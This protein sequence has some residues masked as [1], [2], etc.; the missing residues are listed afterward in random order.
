ME[1]R[2]DFL[3]TDRQLDSKFPV[4]D[5]GYSGTCGGGVT[6][7]T[8]V[9]GNA[10][11]PANSYFVGMLVELGWNGYP[12]ST[13]KQ[14]IRRITA[15]DSATDK[16]TVEANWSPLPSGADPLANWTWRIL[17]INSANYYTNA[18]VEETLK[19]ADGNPYY[20]GI[21]YFDYD[22][23]NDSTG[24]GTFG[25]PYKTI[26]GK[27][28][29]DKLCYIKSD[30]MELD[31]GTLFT[32]NGDGI[33]RPFYIAG[34]NKRVRMRRAIYC[35]GDCIDGAIFNLDFVIIT[36]WV[37]T[38]PFH[39]FYLGS[40]S[41]SFHFQRY[42]ITAFAGSMFACFWNAQGVASNFTPNLSLANMTL[43][44]CHFESLPSVG[45][46]ANLLTIMETSLV[47]N[48]TMTANLALIRAA[49]SGDLIVSGV[50]ALT[51]TVQ[52]GGTVSGTLAL[53]N[54]IPS[55][56]R[57]SVALDADFHNIAYWRMSC[58][59][60]I[61]A[62]AYDWPLAL[63]TDRFSI[64]P[65]FSAVSRLE[66]I[67]GT[68]SVRAF[69]KRNQRGLEATLTMTEDDFNDDILE[70]ALKPTYYL[71]SDELRDETLTITSQTGVNGGKGNLIKVNSEIP[72]ASR[73]EMIG[74]VDMGGGVT[75]WVYFKDVVSLAGVYYYKVMT[76]NAA[77]QYLFS[78][79][80]YKG[81]SIRIHYRLYTLTEAPAVDRITY[82]L[83]NVG[84]K[85][86]AKYL[87][88]PGEQSLL[89]G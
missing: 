26:S 68:D 48:I 24:T 46:P 62:S 84:L 17:T 86:A 19:D 76:I 23:G 21:L 18:E 74:S 16:I 75:V 67:D 72:K 64:K 31:T 73:L 12:T 30:T 20:S 81:R 78:H 22:S 37:G 79:C 11:P 56:V 80:V 36:Q 51:D 49:I 87:T 7:N 63:D 55:L 39:A 69:W 42:A 34:Y 52:V 44:N 59:R 88:D 6:A 58:R 27:V 35:V 29:S 25:N 70:T 13:T 50:H 77:D 82:N 41:C 38:A 54:S 8:L 5:S 83:L 53:I 14:Q 28:A 40:F 61:F 15:Y 43:R 45:T 57:Q 10:I 85:F 9:L 60:E 65:S 66:Y 1:I 47:G 4:Q 32:L 71:I 2:N 89:E 3:K 33:Q